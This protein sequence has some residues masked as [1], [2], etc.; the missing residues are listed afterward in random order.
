MKNNGIHIIKYDEKKEKKFYI[1][2]KDLNLVDGINLAN[3]LLKEDFLKEEDEE[4]ISLI[5]MKKIRGL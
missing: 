2:G 5:S 1:M 3:Y 4:K